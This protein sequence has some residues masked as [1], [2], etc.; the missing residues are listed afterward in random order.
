MGQVEDCALLIL[1][2]DEKDVHHLDLLFLQK[3]DDYLSLLIVNHSE[4]FGRPFE[5]SL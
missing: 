1:R 5:I 2:E 4:F 3:V